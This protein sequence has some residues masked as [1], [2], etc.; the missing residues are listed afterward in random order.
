MNSNTTRTPEDF[1][2]LGTTPGESR[3]PLVMAALAVLDGLPLARVGRTVAVDT[4]GWYVRPDTLANASGARRITARHIHRGQFRPAS[5][6]S[7]KAYQALA[8]R[9]FTR[10]GWT[11][12]EAPC[13]VLL[14]Q[15]PE[16]ADNSE[17]PCDRS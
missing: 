11:V 4:T 3:D 10:A 9:R 8:A 17:A 12:L 6:A 13:N 2:V 14:A 16:P 7:G 1:P 15:A 5:P